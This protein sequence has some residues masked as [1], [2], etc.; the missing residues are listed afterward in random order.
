MSTLTVT[1]LSPTAVDPGFVAAS[2]GGDQFT[3]D[4]ETVLHVRNDGASERTVTL[5]SQ[6]TDD[7]GVDGDDLD[8]TVPAGGERAVYLGSY[9]GRFRDP[10]GYCQIIYDDEADLTVAVYRT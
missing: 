7:I 5:T 3:V 2:S 6:V 1:Q 10:D 9:S 8:I 4:G